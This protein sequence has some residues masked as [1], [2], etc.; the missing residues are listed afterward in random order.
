MLKPLGQWAL[1]A[2]LTLT[3]LTATQV[4]ANELNTEEA[5][6]GYSLGVMV[7][8][9]LHEDIDQLDI[10]SFTLALQD[11]YAGNT[12]RL[13]DEQ[14][15]EII[16]ALQERLMEESMARHQ[17]VAQTNLER[18]QAYLAENAQRDGV[19][20]LDSGLQYEVVRAGDGARPS[21]TDQVQVH[22]EGRLVNGEVF[23]SSYTRNQP[24][25][26]R[27]NQVIQGWQEALQLMPV[28][29]EWM[30]YIPAELAYG[31]NGAG[32]A[33]GP[34]EA[35]VFKVELLDITR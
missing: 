22:Y 26:F 33:I 17:Q 6:T 7:G 2:G 19:Q 1:A 13:N 20:T 24:A 35:L 28:G 25:S 8:R 9:Q 12:P 21:A 5:R 29:S 30:I 23:D 4:M 11:I 16:N 10:E 18:G 3:S 27:V 15:G 31:S 32:G 34:N 14:I